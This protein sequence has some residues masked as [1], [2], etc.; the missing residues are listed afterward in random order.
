MSWVDLALEAGMDPLVL[1]ALIVVIAELERTKHHMK[2]Q[3]NDTK[4]EIC[5]R[6]DAAF[7][8]I[9]RLE[10]HHMTDGGEEEVPIHVEEDQ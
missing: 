4:D 9:S 10:G 2:R 3:M 5:S 6:I 8:R 7:R 1:L